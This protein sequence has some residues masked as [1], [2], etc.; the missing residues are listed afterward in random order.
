[1]NTITFPLATPRDIETAA[2]FVAE[3]QRQGLRFNAARNDRH[4]LVIEIGGY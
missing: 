2:E 4:E 1:V 3:L